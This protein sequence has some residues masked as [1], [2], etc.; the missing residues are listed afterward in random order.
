MPSNHAIVDDALMTDK[1]EDVL[2]TEAEQQR[3]AR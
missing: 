1:D 2:M 3:D